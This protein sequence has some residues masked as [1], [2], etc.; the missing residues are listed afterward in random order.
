M[1]EMRA[2]AKEKPKARKTTL[3]TGTKGLNCDYESPTLPQTTESVTKFRSS[4]HASSTGVAVLV[5]W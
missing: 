3:R 4:D 2:S 1:Y 5:S